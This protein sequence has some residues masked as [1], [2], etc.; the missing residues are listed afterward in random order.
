M[1]AS[2]LHPCPL[3][4]LLTASRS[5]LAGIDLDIGQYRQLEQDIRD[6]GFNLKHIC[7]PEQ[8][9]DAQP[10]DFPALLD[11]IPLDELTR[12]RPRIV[13][14][15]YWL[16]HWEGIKD[17]QGQRCFAEL[18]GGNSVIRNVLIQHFRGIPFLNINVAAKDLAGKW[19]VEL[20]CEKRKQ[21]LAEAQQAGPY[22]AWKFGVAIR[23]LNQGMVRLPFAEQLQRPR[24]AAE[25]YDQLLASARALGI[26]HDTLARA[27]AQAFPEGE[28]VEIVKCLTG[29]PGGGL[30]GALVFVARTR[31]A[32]PK[33]IKLCDWHTA[34]AEYEGARFVIGPRLTNFAAVTV[35]PGND[36]G[37]SLFRETGSERA[38]GLL[39]YTIVGTPG[40]DLSIRSLGHELTQLRTE[41]SRIDTLLP[42]LQQTLEQVLGQLHGRTPRLDKRTLWQW[43]GNVLPP[44]YRIELSDD[45]EATATTLV[46]YHA[47][48]FKP[49]SAA[50]LAATDWRA[51]TEGAVIELTDAPLVEIAMDA[52][53]VTVTHPDLGFRLNC[54][55]SP[56]NTLLKDRQDVKTG[57]PL[58]V[59]GRV[60]L[61]PPPDWVRALNADASVAWLLPQTWEAAARLPFALSFSGHAGAIHGDLNLDNL[62]FSDATHLGW[63][64]DFERSVADGLIAFDFAKLEVELLAHQ[65]I[66]ALLTIAERFLHLVP[67][68]PQLLTTILMSVN[69]FAGTPAAIL[70]LWRTLARDRG[71]LI[72]CFEPGSLTHLEGLLTMLAAMRLRA[73]TLLTTRHASDE[74]P[75]DL[76][77]A[78]TVYALVASKFA[79]RAGYKQ[80]VTYLQQVAEHYAQ[81]WW[82]DDS[83]S[84]ADNADP[85]QV[86]APHCRHVTPAAARAIDHYCYTVAQEPPTPS[87]LASVTRTLQGTV[88]PLT[89]PESATVWDVASTGCVANISPIVGYLWLMARRQQEAD[90]IV[91]KSASQGASCGTVDVLAAG[92]YRFP[93]TPA[94]IQQQVNE[95]GGVFCRQSD[96]IARVDRVTMRR[97]KARNLMKHPV[98]TLASILAKKQLLGDTHAVLDIKLGRDSKWIV[99]DPDQAARL[100][101]TQ[102]RH[103]TLH[104]EP[105]VIA[106]LQAALAPMLGAPQTTQDNL[107]CYHDAAGIADTSIRE[108]RVLAS[109]A[110]VPQ[111]RAIGRLLILHQLDQTLSQDD[112]WSDWP[113]A[114]R[115]FY[116]ETLKRA[117]AVPE[118]VSTAALGAAW[119][120][121]KQQLP[122]FDASGGHEYKKLFEALRRV[123]NSDQPEQRHHAHPLLP[124]QAH[125]D[126]VH[127]VSVCAPRAGHLNFLDA[128]ALDALFEALCGNDLFDAAVGIW[129]HSLPGEPVTPARPLLTVFFRPATMPERTLGQRLDALL[130][131]S[132]HI[133][134]AA[135]RD[136]A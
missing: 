71:L 59:R 91:P 105:D 82:L 26:Q 69:S 95:Y 114:Y 7:A 76:A 8:P 72:D 10:A 124:E 2:A 106:A 104:P 63:L 35:T 62:Q 9:A 30:S 4:Y 15:I 65:L 89:W 45:S 101:G 109:S 34:Q 119:Q 110:D 87:L 77:M 22:F 61:A 129:L 14:F 40:G 136:P 12:A 57:H 113:A 111:G 128:Y 32:I 135:E 121:L 102:T 73:R 25:P 38:L 19:G 120:A 29:Q 5:A 55:G 58:R 134:P 17:K 41:P 117:C 46:S 99:S 130:H 44:L 54:V 112:P 79:D 94:R 11:A 81:W 3:V 20:E 70:P 48:G 92:G 27:L 64:I 47:Q 6:E 23:E 122:I 31:T 97:R 127:V 85:A 131:D 74:P 125:A 108:L 80:R 88:R 53:T 100:C 1:S 98:L 86:L 83:A 60:T 51:L 78:L 96:A 52:N 39:V 28:P 56:I 133:D 90:L 123:L 50:L 13:A 93:D 16:E 43:L 115:T 21:E 116:L 66:P 84:T 67:D 107:L 126:D 103:R 37:P 75:D 68:A 118:T 24:V 132:A 36:T 33:L 49:E 42:R 18:H